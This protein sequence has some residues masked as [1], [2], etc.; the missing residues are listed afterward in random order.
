MLDSR[1]VIQKFVIVVVDLET[2]D[3]IEVVNY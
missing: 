3:T 2:I 1:L